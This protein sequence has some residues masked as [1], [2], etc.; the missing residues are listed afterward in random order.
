ML[1]A[2]LQYL[3]GFSTGDSILLYSVF[4]NAHCQMDETVYIIDYLLWKVLIQAR[5]KYIS[6]FMNMHFQVEEPVQEVV[7]EESNLMNVNF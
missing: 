2:R 3:Q 7:P 4:Q 1:S 6:S 5:W